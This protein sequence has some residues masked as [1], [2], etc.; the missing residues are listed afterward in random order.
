[1]LR[2]WHT[3]I[4]NSPML[5]VYLWVIFCFLPFFFIFRKSSY[6]EIS[7]GITFLML[8]FIFYRFSANS[9]NGLVYMWISFEMVINIVMTILYGYVYLSI[10]TAFF[11]GNIRRPVGFYI[12]YGLHIGFTVISTAIGF[13]VELH[14]FLSQLPFVV[15]A[16]LAVVLLPL[17]IYSKNK[18]ANLEGQL[19]TANERIAELIVFEERQRIARDLHD[20]LGQK[21]SMIGLKSDLAARLIERDAQQA[22]V[23]VKD[24]RQIASIALKE[25]RE[26]VSDMR[27]TKFEDELLRV[28]QILKAAEMEFLF[29]GDKE[30]LQVPPL[31]ENVLSMCLKEAVNNVVKHSSATKCEIAFHQNFKEVYLVVRDNGQGLAKKQAWKTGNGLKGMRERLEFINGTFKLEDENGTTLTVS[32]PVAITHQTVTENLKNRTK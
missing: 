16:I 4:P 19:E 14:L 20:T 32:I 9:K 1:M 28:A 3:I 26:L 10:F 24:I 30:S 12:M 29:E 22:L 6:I 2:K 31:V 15:L 11:I 17:T 5:S 7:I 21:L 25:V 13:F 27:T 8:Y 18:R 23:E